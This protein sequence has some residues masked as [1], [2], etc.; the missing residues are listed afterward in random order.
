MT[1]SEYLSKT[2]ES[3]NLAEDSDELKRLRERR[4]EVED[5]LREEFGSSPTIRYG[6][7][8][9]KGTMNKEAYDL[10][11]ISYFPRDDDDAGGTIEELYEN[12][13]KALLKKYVVVVKTS[14]IR[15]Q[16]QNYQDFH[17]D[18]VPGRFVDDKKEDAFLHQTGGTKD[19]LKTNLNTHIEHVKGSGLVSVIRLM[20]LWRVRRGL[21]IK[22]FGL[23]LL[24]IEGLKEKKSA[25]LE[26]Q[27]DYL[28]RTLRDDVTSINIKDP[29]NPNG[30]DLSELLNDTV[31]SELSTAAAS[32]LSTI[33]QQGWEAIFGKLASSD[34]DKKAAIVEA[35]TSVSV[36]S[37]PWCRR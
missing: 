20:K 23:E 13:K 11:I 5:L 3:Q 8:K 36:A 33:Q 6:G 9:A 12:T 27:L 28:W 19:R 37:R 25:N 4:E 18:V 15:L 10:D 34:E 35:A 16:S 2:I 30:N 14:A 29:A 7:S 1:P 32:T 21:A 31:R 26:T 24:T 17:V 22:H